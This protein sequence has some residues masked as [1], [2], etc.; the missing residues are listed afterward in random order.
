MLVNSAMSVSQKRSTFQPPTS[1]R[2]ASR[3]RSC[4]S[5]S[6]FERP[7]RTIWK[8]MRS[9]SVSSLISGRAASPGTS[10]S[11]FVWSL[12]ISQKAAARSAP[13][14]LNWRWKM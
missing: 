3:I 5:M 12:Y 7:P 4:S 1:S 10:E 8:E 9:S 13:A 6:A 14:R 11:V 2:M